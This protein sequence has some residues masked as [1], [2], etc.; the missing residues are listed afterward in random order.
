MAKKLIKSDKVSETSTKVLPVLANAQSATAIVDP[1]MRER[2]D[3]LSRIAKPSFQSASDSRRKYD[4]EWLGRNLFWRG[5]QFSRYLP[6]TQTVVLAVRQSARIPVNLTTAYMRSIRNQVTAFRPKFEVLPTVPNSDSSQVQARYAQRLLDYYFDRL[7]LKMKIKETIVQALMYSIGGPWQIVY[8]ELTKEVKIWLLDPFDFYMDP[9]AEDPNECE[10][11][12]KAARQPIAAVTSNP[13][14]SLEARREVKGGSEILA[15]S[16]QKQFLLQ[17]TRTISPKMQTSSPFVILYEGSFRR[18]REDGTRYMVHCIWTEQNTVPLLYEELDTDEFDYVVYRG[19]LV[20]KEPYGESWI[21]HVM[22]INR[23]INTLE[24]SALEYNSR[25]AKGRLVVDRDAGVRAI[26]NVHGE[27][28]SKNRGSQ[29]QS[30][31]MAPLANSVPEQIERMNKYAMDISGVHEASLGSVPTG[32]RSGIGV[33]EL[34]QSDSSSQDDLV[35]NLED[36]LTEVAMKILK[37]IAQNYTSYKVIKDLGVREGDEKYFA[38]IGKQAAKG[39]TKAGDKLGKPGQVKIGPDWFDVAEIGDDNNIRVTIGSWLGYTKEALQQ[40]VQ[41]YFQIGLID[42][43]TA[44]KLLEFGDID[45][46]IQKTRLEAILKRPPQ[47][48][49]N[50][51]PQVDQYD[52]A[53]SEND[54]VLEGKVSTTKDAYALVTPDQ[55]HMVHIAV[56][57]DALGKGFDEILGALIE[58]HQIA[59]EHGVGM[60]AGMPTPPPAPTQGGQMGQVGGTGAFPQGG[61]PM[62]AQGGG[63]PGQAPQEAP[64]G[65]VSG[66][67]LP[68]QNLPAVQAAN[69]NQAANAMA[70]QQVGQ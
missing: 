37:K 43:G 54:M 61:A 47:Q 57:Q 52:L 45:S 27:I 29:I 64:P 55:D 68:Q 42:Q 38:V 59:L 25:I 70:P 3:F 12:I 46:V 4:Q 13:S 24:S 50:G 26:H 5:Y 53:L 22:V 32:M 16:P 34:K 2:Q 62:S 63:Q 21:K 56:H 18:Y 49:A 58:A 35:D 48:G 17:T 11:M 30:L 20:P 65:P 9:L 60:Q 40:K 28:I 15:A 6:E 69:T 41:A 23:A 14:Y 33:A 7:K 31:D 51:Q 67:Q 44:L 10:Y 66:T 1:Q 39:K 19:D 8:D 36:F